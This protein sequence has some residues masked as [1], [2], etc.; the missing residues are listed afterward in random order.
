V[1]IGPSKPCAPRGLQG[2]EVMLAVFADAER[3]EAVNE[4][5]R[6]RGDFLSG[7]AGRVGE[8]R[9]RKLIASKGRTKGILMRVSVL[10][11]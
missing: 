6:A 8:R 10:G 1:V 3:V 4:E 11:G 2:A 5:D 7:A 9:R